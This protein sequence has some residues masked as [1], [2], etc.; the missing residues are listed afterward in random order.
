MTSTRVTGSA[1]GQAAGRRPTILI[2]DDDQAIRD[3]LD[4][5]FAA[6]GFR[7]LCAED[8]QTGL[9]LCARRRPDV[10]LLDL[11]MPGL[12]GLGFLREFR[13]AYGHE[14]PPI[15]IMSAVQHAANHAQAAGVAGTFLKPF[16]LEELLAAV[17]AAPRRPVAVAAEHPERVGR[18]RR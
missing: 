18:A 5:A 1:D 16:D 14:G 11:M 8:G 13:R 2:V 15:Y 10:I 9:A 12:D 17:T 6:E 3:F 7:V 4:S